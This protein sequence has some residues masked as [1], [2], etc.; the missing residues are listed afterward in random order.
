MF[1]E[2]LLGPR[3]W[4]EHLT[5][6]LAPWEQVVSLGGSWRAGRTVGTEVHVPGAVLVGRQE[7]TDEGQIKVGLM[8]E[9]RWLLVSAQ[10]EGRCPKGASVVSHMA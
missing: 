3:P 8:E 4:A 1:I 6:W 7:G 9:R 5:R 10:Q 2:Y